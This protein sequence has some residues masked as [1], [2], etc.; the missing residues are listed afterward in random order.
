MIIT[1]FLQ[2]W[3]CTMR[4]LCVFVCLYVW[5][6]EEVKDRRVS[7]AVA[8][9]PKSPLEEDSVKLGVPSVQVGVLPSPES[10]GVQVW[11]RTGVGP[12]LES[13]L[14]VDRE[15]VRGSSCTSLTLRTQHHHLLV[16]THTDTHTRTHRHVHAHTALTHPRT[17]TQHSHG[18]SH[19]CT[20]SYW[21]VLCEDKHQDPAIMPH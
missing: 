10:G 21:S 15:S 18:Y 12:T 17:G 11:V 5:M 14:S 16:H 7:E 8:S 1:V 13:T 2:T 9:I 19:P 4:I 3:V 20:S 6:C